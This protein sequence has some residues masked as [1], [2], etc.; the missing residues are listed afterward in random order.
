[1]AIKVVRLLPASTWG[2]FGSVLAIS[3]SIPS[4]ALQQA[5]DRQDLPALQAMITQCQQAAQA[6][7]QSADAQYR[8]ALAYSYAAEVAIEARDKKKA[9][10][11]AEAGVE[12]AKKAISATGANAEYHR[13]LGELCGQAIP[14]NPVFGSL[15]YG[16]C[17]RDEINKAI[18]LN[19]KFALAYVSRGVGN[20]YVPASMGGSIDLALKD[21]EK[22]IA[23]DSDL[24]DAYLWRGVALRK[25][26]RD[27]EARASLRRALE[28]DPNRLWTKQL[29]EK[30]PAR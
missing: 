29:L 6:K 9:E 19:G 22:A 3:A 23:L 26:N 14:G 1:M 24:A 12:A 4:S 18:E 27:A 17:A 5:R 8:L 11:L 2:L 16:Q 28:L 15:K 25:A 30:T 7:S 20:F 13:L 21:F 10:Q